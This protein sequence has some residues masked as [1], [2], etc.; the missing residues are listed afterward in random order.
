[1]ATLQQTKSS[2][3]A[4]LKAGE[5]DRKF[6]RNPDKDGLVGIPHGARLAVC[7]QASRPGRSRIALLKWAIL[8]VV[9]RRSVC[10]L[11]DL[12]TPDWG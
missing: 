3:G 9:L 5:Q 11:A 1:M 12:Q 7:R 2:D 4:L 6:P 10:S 8:A